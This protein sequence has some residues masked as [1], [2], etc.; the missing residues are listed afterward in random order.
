ML[1]GE[2][3]PT[4]RLD[5]RRLELGL[6][7]GREHRECAARPSI[8]VPGMRGAHLV[9]LADTGMDPRDVVERLLEPRLLVHRPPLERVL[10]PGVGGEQHAALGRRVG[11]RIV[12][13]PDRHVG[14]RG[15][16]ED[17]VVGLPDALAD[18]EEHLGRGVVIQLADGAL[19]GVRER[20]ERLD[21]A[22]DGERKRADGVVAAGS[23]ATRL[24]LEVDGHAFGILVDGED[25]GAEADLLMKFGVERVRESVHPA[26]DLLHVDVGLADVLA[27]DLDDRVVHVG[28][29]EVH[30]RVVLDGSLRPALHAQELEQRVL[31]VIA[32]DLLPGLVACLLDHPSQVTGRAF[33]ELVGGPTALVLGQVEGQ[34]FGLGVGLGGRHPDAAH[35]DETLRIAH[36][37]RAKRQPEE[38]AV[39][40]RQVVDAR[41]AHAARLGVQT[42]REAPQRVDAAAH[43]ILGFE[44]QDLVALPLQFVRGDQSR[45]AG[46][47]HD[48][49]LGGAGASVEAIGRDGEGLGRDGRRL[50]G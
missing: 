28:F 46:A 2:Q 29:D 16:A 26:R 47:Q 18:L 44:D 20:L 42:R 19:L 4:L 38:V 1:A 39:F 11:R 17:A 9:H 8:A 49:P 6:L 25:L 36:H 15:T 37:E 27:Q 23:E 31:V 41:D 30:D 40:E 35:V 32:H 13:P 48:D 33:P 5:D 21:R 43:P 12:H 50:I 10:A 24:R 14:D 7:L 3:D 45:Q 34:A 22:Q